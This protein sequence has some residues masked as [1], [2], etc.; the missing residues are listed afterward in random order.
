MILHAITI[1]YIEIIKEA[2]HIHVDITENATCFNHTGQSP[3]GDFCFMQLK[4]MR[5]RYTSFHIAGLQ[6]FKNLH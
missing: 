6:Q 3:S 5:K 4:T 1:L 2:R